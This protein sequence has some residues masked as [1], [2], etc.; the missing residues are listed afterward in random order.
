MKRWFFLP[1]IIGAGVAWWWPVKNPAKTTPT[2]IP[3]RVAPATAIKPLTNYLVS[4]QQFFSQAISLSQQKDGDIRQRNQKVTRLINQAITLATTAISHYPTDPRG[5]AQR[6]RIYQAITA[7]LPNARQIALVDWLRAAQL[8]GNN[9]DYWRQAGRLCQRMG[10]L[11]C[12]VDNLRRAVD[13]SPTDGQLLLE[14]ARA[15]S[16][17]G[18]LQAAY[19][20]YQ[21]LLGILVDDRQQAQI[22]QELAGLKKLLAKTKGVVAA[23][24]V[25]PSPLPLEN[26]NA[27]KL[28][29]QAQQPLII[30]AGDE[31]S[32]ETSGQ[33]VANALSG[34]SVLPGGEKEITVRNQR[35][36][37]QTVVYL[38]AIDDSDNQPLRLLQKGPGFFRVGLSHALN[39]DLRFK[40]LIAPQK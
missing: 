25:S 11:A 28:E 35:V 6:A 3:A 40:W 10:N 23:E 39:H 18:R 24:P 12:G 21:Q 30:A 7:Y 4:S 15:E 1:I 31:A 13:L 34:T 17:A 16:Q 29:A 2:S 9:P 5:Y 8:A 19:Q 33:A 38:T 32:P 20:H 36:N 37:A 14:L 22:R 26:L 27:P